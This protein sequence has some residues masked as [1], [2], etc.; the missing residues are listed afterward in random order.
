MTTQTS[1][2]TAQTNSKVLRWC[3][4][5]VVRYQTTGVHNHDDDQ[6]GDGRACNGRAGG[7]ALYGRCEETQARQPPEFDNASRNSGHVR[8]AGNATQNLRHIWNLGWN[9]HCTFGRL[10]QLAL[11]RRDECGAH[12]EQ[13]QSCC[14]Q[15]T[16]TANAAVQRANGAQ[17]QLGGCSALTKA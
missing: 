11:G 17:P 8:T 4:R 15:V 5:C 2:R 3:R 7:C 10:V 6:T 16:G 14:S 9:G 12:L 13:H 1:E